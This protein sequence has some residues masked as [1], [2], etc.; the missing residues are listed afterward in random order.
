MLDDLN[1]PK[2]IASL[3][4]LTARF[5]KCDNDLEK[6]E[7]KGEIFAIADFL[8]IVQLDSKAWFQAETADGISVSDI[9]NLIEQRVAAKKSKDF[10]QADAIRDELAQ[11]GIQIKDTREGTQWVREN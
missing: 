8:N 6:A 4:D 5:F 9:E 7:L 3:H 1:T 2:V 11:A 10:A